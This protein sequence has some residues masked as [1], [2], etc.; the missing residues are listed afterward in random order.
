M[1]SIKLHKNDLLKYDFQ[2]FQDQFKQR[3]PTELTQAHSSFRP[4]YESLFTE[5][6]FRPSYVAVIGFDEPRWSLSHEKRLV[7]VLLEL[8]A[9]GIVS[10]D[11]LNLA[12]LV[13]LPSI[14]FLE[15]EP[16]KKAPEAKRLRFSSGSP[17]DSQLSLQSPKENLP[18]E[19]LQPRPAWAHSLVS[20]QND[21]D[22]GIAALLEILLLNH[23]EL[24]KHEQRTEDTFKFILWK[25]ASEKV[26]HCTFES[27]L[28]S[29]GHK[30][31]LRASDL[32]DAFNHL[33]RCSHLQPPNVR[34]SRHRETLLV[35]LT[36]LKTSF[37][38][39]M[40]GLRV[41][42]AVLR[43]FD[44]KQPIAA[45]FPNGDKQETLSY[46]NAGLAEDDPKDGQARKRR[47][48]RGSNPRRLRTSRLMS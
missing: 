7:H 2:R 41:P 45:W 10:E 1:N 40:E 31:K 46:L 17:N 19:Q 47:P 32:V 25:L 37:V 42:A 18:T 14:P 39:D 30:N 33:D 26:G 11:K 4:I 8:I 3:R 43:M 5:T 38:T 6:D 35:E 28:A 21:S 24:A 29:L 15:F 13:S 34:A 36:S 20:L 48:T 9:S 44:L 22:L 16:L 27:P 12:E 23:G